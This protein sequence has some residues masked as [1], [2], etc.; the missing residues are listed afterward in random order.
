MT[1]LQIFIFTIIFCFIGQSNLTAQ[2]DKIFISKFSDE[3]K[4]LKALD[5]AIALDFQMVF[6]TCKRFKVLDRRYYNSWISKKLKKNAMYKYQLSSNDVTYNVFGEIIY[7]SKGDYYAIEYGLEEV[8]PNTI[9]F[10]DNILFDTYSDLT[11]KQLRQERIYARL[12]KEFE[13]CRN[14]EIAL[15]KRYYK[16]AINSNQP[17]NYWW[18]KVWGWIFRVFQLY[19]Y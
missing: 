1:Q 9:L 19:N 10:V 17:F 14:Q 7:N 18:Y 4:G 15:D 8:N 16:P 12:M 3:T 11:N 6:Q 5:E 13:L 2:R